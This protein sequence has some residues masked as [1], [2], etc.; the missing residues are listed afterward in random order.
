M[1]YLFFFHGN[2][3]QLLPVARKAISA[4]GLV[5]FGL[6]WFDLVGFGLI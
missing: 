2:L 1:L 6:I 5:W 3:V 4:I